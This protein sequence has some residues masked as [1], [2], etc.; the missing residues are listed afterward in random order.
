MR[1]S[2][3][4]KFT[5]VD[6]LCARG[7]AQ[8]ATAVHGELASSHLS[9]AATAQQ[10]TGPPYNICIAWT[11]TAQRNTIIM[12]K[13]MRSKPW[14]AQFHV[15]LAAPQL[16]LLAAN[17]NSRSH[18]RTAARDL[19][20]LVDDCVRRRVVQEPGAAAVGALSDMF[21]SWESQALCDVLA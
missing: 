12:L 14:Y 8:Y 16:S 1:P 7:G 20:A 21:P 4:S 18:I 5:H 6:V 3:H 19:H 2:V 9:A 11:V 13:H 15:D 17:E 10:C